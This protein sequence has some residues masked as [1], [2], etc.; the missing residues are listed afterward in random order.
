[1]R[2]PAWWPHACLEGIRRNSR[3][4]VNAT[5]AAATCRR[6]H[7]LPGRIVIRECYVVALGQHRRDRILNLLQSQPGRVLNYFD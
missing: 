6:N 2:S 7:E 3:L 5:P 4:L 1:M